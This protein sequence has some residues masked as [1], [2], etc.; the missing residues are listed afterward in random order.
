MASLRGPN[1]SSSKRGT[2]VIGTSRVLNHITKPCTS[3]LVYTYVCDLIW[4][5]NS[6]VTFAAHPTRYLRHRA[7]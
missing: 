7:S 2:V 6:P 4:P 3:N 5:T 1:L